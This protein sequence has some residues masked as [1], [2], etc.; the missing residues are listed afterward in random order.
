VQ[1]VATGQYLNNAR[2]VVRGTELVACTDETGTY[3]L[4]RLIG[5]GKAREL[6]YTGRIIDAQECL[7][8]GLANEVTADDQVVERALAIA[9][10]IAKNGRL[11]VRGAK[12]AL[13]AI[14]RPGNDHAI[15]FESSIQ[16]VLFD[17]ADK[18]TRMAAFLKKPP[19]KG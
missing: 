3:R 9:E 17:S 15:A 4:P 5:L 18:Q 10:E 1:N 11:A 7:R 8:I 14:S 19:Q 16:A 13:N 12:Q 6:I 2:V